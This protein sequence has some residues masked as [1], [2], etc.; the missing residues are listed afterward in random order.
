[1][2]NYLLVLIQRAPRVWIAPQSVT[3]LYQAFQSPLLPK[4]GLF[5]WGTST[6]A[7]L[8]SIRKEHNKRTL[9]VCSSNLRAISDHTV[10]WAKANRLTTSLINS[11]QDLLTLNQW[12][13]S[14]TAESIGILEGLRRV[15]SEFRTV[16]SSHRHHT[17][18]RALGV[19]IRF[20]ITFTLCAEISGWPS[21]RSANQGA[22]SLAKLGA[23]SAANTSN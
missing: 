9:Q 2:Q 18:L 13:L 7:T 14:T 1:M 11:W 4:A 8:R 6:A 19:S 15:S 22:D 21:H 10:F 5:L 17:R 20:F 23:I 3:Q 12:Y 16:V